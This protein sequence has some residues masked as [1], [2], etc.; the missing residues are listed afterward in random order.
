MKT[1]EWNWQRTDWPEF[2]Y[3][4]L[5]LEE[6]EQEFFR[7]AGICLGVT[8]HLTKVDQQELAIELAGNE[9]LQTSAIEGE[10]LD[11]DSVQSS[12][13][14]LFGLKVG[15]TTVSN[16]PA[17]SG[18]AEMMNDVYINF[19]RP[20]SK[21]ELC[22]WHDMLMNGIR[23][24]NRGK[25]RTHQEAM[26]VVSGR[27][28]KPKV[29]FEAPPSSI[30]PEE[31]A[32]F[33][34]WFNQTA[35]GSKTALPPLTRAGIAHLY[36]VSIH[37][38]EDGN[39]RLGR[40]LVEKVLSQ[41]AGYP[42]LIA[43][44]TTISEKKRDYYNNLAANS[45]DNEITN[46]LL[47]F[48]KVIIDAQKNT[49]KQIEFTLSKSHFFAVHKNT[50]NARQLKVIK[51][52]FREGPC[53]FKGGLSAGNYKSIAK[54]SSATATRDLQNLVMSGILSKSGQFKNARYTLV[55]P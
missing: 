16:R 46:W 2:S 45:N 52:V 30:I 31:M 55:M 10:M 12:L 44:S 36:F 8:K 42:A 43:L 3:N 5:L 20:L 11:R 25:Y 32:R 48:A 40:A 24:I 15:D 4:A 35:P 49:L 28:D 6:F 14:R 9:A 21:K 13:R 38:F 47:Y 54:T 18:I 34:I 51:R 39:G 22:E 50:L 1:N 19:K 37:P 29:H 7:H 17:E 26:Q 23:H 33:I 41:T 27:Y 53:G